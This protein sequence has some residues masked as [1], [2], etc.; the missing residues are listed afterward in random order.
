MHLLEHMELREY[1]ADLIGEIAA[2]HH[3]PPHRVAEVF[4]DRRV[5]APAFLQP[6]EWEV[7]ALKLAFLLR[8]ADA[9]H[10]DGL[11]APWF[12][13]ACADP[14]VFP[15]IT[16]DSR[17]RSVTDQDSGRRWRITSGSQFSHAERKA[18]WLAY[19]TVCMIDRE[20]RD[21][22]ALMR[23]EG[24]PCFAATSVLGVESPEA[25]ARQVPLRWE[26]VNAAPKIADV[27]KVIWALGGSTLYGDEPWIALRELLQNALYAVRALRALGIRGRYQGRSRGQSRTRPDGARPAGWTDPHR[28]WHEPPRAH[29]HPARFREFLMASHVLRAAARPVL[30]GPASTPWVSS[31]SVSFEPPCW[32][33]KCG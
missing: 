16:G 24:W 32:A 7:D 28:D 15:R 17:R 13:F 10:I 30:P 12:L 8:T 11:R 14:K 6:A 4:A 21:A 27:P 2:S 3:W 23:D 31:V 5:S 25:F 20:L 1:Y 26:P 18:W 29:E 9:A 22:H 19:D 33:R